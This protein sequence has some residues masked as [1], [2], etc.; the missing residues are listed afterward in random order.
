MYDWFG[1]QW[2]F[3]LFVFISLVCCGILFVFW[4]YG[5]CIWVWSK[6]VYGGDVIEELVDGFEK[7]VDEEVN[8][9]CDEVLMRVISYV[10][11]L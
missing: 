8:I 5:V 3:S 7:V 11:N 9:V 6:Y 10:S 1:D 2:V 4:C